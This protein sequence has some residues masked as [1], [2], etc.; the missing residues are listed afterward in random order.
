[1]DNGKTIVLGLLR[2]QVFINISIFVVIQIGDCLFVIFLWFV[3]LSSSSFGLFRKKEC[4]RRLLFWGSGWWG[5]NDAH[6]VVTLTP[7][8]PTKHSISRV[9]ARPNNLAC[10]YYD[11][12]ETKEISLE[13]F[14]SGL[15]SGSPTFPLTN[16]A[17][18]MNSVWVANSFIHRKSISKLNSM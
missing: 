14:G 15:A 3:W 12:E 13:K 17:P 16:Q 8:L 10:F 18:Q 2:H 6:C 9:L 5:G 4:G 11:D 7:L 1:L